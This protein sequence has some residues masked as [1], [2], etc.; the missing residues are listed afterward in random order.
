MRL[1]HALESRLPAAI[2]ECIGDFR[3]RAFADVAPIRY[4]AA[5]FSLFDR[6][7][8][9]FESLERYYFNLGNFGRPTPI[10]P[11]TR[12]T[13]DWLFSPAMAEAMS[14]PRYGSLLR[15]TGLR[16][17]WAGTR[18]LPDFPRGPFD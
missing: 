10:T 15:R 1:A 7:D 6:L 16:D 14:D 9:G 3:T 18:T 8:L 4:S 12:R 2:E 13:T 17:Y 11:S 5:I